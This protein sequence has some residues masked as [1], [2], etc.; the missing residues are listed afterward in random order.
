MSTKD[1]GTRGE[2]IASIFLKENGYKIIDVN[3]KTRWCEIDIIAKK[4]DVMHFIEVKYRKSADY[5]DGF[6][7]IT[8]KKLQQMRFSAELWLHQSNY[9]GDC[10][11]SAVSVD[12]EGQSI[13][14]LEDL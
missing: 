12:N 2:N 9:S 1:I 11:L 3:W 5:G 7:Y 4:S 14:F 8:P 10:S 13:T 6:S